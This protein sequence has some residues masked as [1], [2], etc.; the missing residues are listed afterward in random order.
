MTSTHSRLR[1][2]GSRAHLEVGRRELPRLDDIEG[3]HI[4]TA[5]NEAVAGRV[6]DRLQRPLDAIKDV[7]H[8]ACTRAP[9]EAYAASTPCTAVAAHAQMC[10]SQLWPWDMDWA[11][12][13]RPIGS[14]PFAGL[15]NIRRWPTGTSACAQGVHC[16]YCKINHLQGSG[17]S[18]GLGCKAFAQSTK[19]KPA[20]LMVQHVHTCPDRGHLGR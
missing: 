19:A 13:R 14:R 4:D 15:G 7:L 11:G 9:L 3:G 8:D 6:C 12:C 10:S 18:C 17:V 2:T 5:G 1:C 16:E 20:H